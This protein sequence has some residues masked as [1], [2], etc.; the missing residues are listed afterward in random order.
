MADEVLNSGVRGITDLMVMPGLINLDFADVKTVMSEMGKAMMGTGEADGDRRA[1]EAAEAAISNPLLDEVSLK[2]AKGVIINITGGMDLTLFE[3]DEAAKHIRSQVDEDANIIVGSAF[4]E[5]LNGQI[6]V[7]VVATGIAGE[8]MQ[9]PADAQP[10]SASVVSFS[11]NTR[12]QISGAASQPRAEAAV[13][14][15]LE[16]EPVRIMEEDDA[17]LAA[18]DAE[19]ALVLEAQIGSEAEAPAQTDMSQDAALDESA[20]M[21]NASLDEADVEAVVANA[22]VFIAPEPQIPSTATDPVGEPDVFAKADYE[23]AG[24]PQVEKSRSLF[25]R[26]TSFGNKGGASAQS[27]ADAQLNAKTEEAQKDKRKLDRLR[28]EDRPVP[29][30]RS[31]KKLAEEQLEIP[32]FLRRQIN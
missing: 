30:S 21:D 31:E 27:V 5:A 17:R 19:E 15:A 29:S 16:E 23:N 13:A 4:N 32:A 26:M 9:K 22:D 20:A 8:D 6:R 2:G 3:V 18:Q 24:E 12:P 11:R 1:V 14:R 25:R 10:S 28:P 7:S